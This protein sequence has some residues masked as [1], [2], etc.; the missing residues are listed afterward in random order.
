VRELE[1]FEKTYSMPSDEF[2][3]KFESGELTGGH[4]DEWAKAMKAFHPLKGKLEATKARVEAMASA[5]R[6]AFIQCVGSRDKRY[7][8]YCSGFCC[9]H[10]IKE[11]IIAR[12]HDREAEVYIFGMDIRAV[13][14]NFEEYHNRAAEEAGVKFVRSRV[15]EI[16]ETA[17]HNPILWYE[18]TKA[19]EVHSL[20]VD[21]VILATACE[22]SPAAEKFSELLNIPLN[23]FGFYKTKAFPALDTPRE[24]V[25]TCGCAQGPMDIPESVAQASSCAARAAQALSGP[26]AMRLVS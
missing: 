10:S 7:N 6:I 4:Y 2:F 8:K 11:A 14:K 23:D 15:A 19:R 25:F 1:K 3:D 12:E 5:S 21:L 16:T 24:G 9:M 18:D 22:P 17:D 26:E 20:E 13:G